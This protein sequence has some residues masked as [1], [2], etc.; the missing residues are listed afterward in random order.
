MSLYDVQNVPAVRDLKVKSEKSEK[1]EE[2][3]ALCSKTL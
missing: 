2:Q 3:K 1:S